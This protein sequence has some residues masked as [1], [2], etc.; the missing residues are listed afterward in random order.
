MNMTTEKVIIVYGRHNTRQNKVLEFVASVE[1][2]VAAVDKWTFDVVVCQDCFIC[3][4][5]V[6]LFLV[7]IILIEVKRI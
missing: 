7:G 4:F 3:V 6:F 2:N 5:T 1:S